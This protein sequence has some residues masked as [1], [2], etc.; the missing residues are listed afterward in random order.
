MSNQNSD[1]TIFGHPVDEIGLA[2]TVK[3]SH[4]ICTC[5]KGCTKHTGNRMRCRTLCENSGLK[6]FIIIALGINLSCRLA[7]ASG[8]IPAEQF[9]TQDIFSRC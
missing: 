4:Y 2:I 7:N 5:S 6:R 3:H 8:H 1:L 9:P